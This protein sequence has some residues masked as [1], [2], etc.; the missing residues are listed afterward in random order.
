M[1][2]NG[3]C[4]LVLAIFLSAFAL[5]TARPIEQTLVAR[6]LEA[7]SPHADVDGGVFVPHPRPGQ[8]GPSVP[9]ANATVFAPTPTVPGKVLRNPKVSGVRNP[10]K[11]G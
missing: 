10:K 11:G 3:P 1:L 2:L 8:H 6:T 4:T 7:R 5:I 9:D